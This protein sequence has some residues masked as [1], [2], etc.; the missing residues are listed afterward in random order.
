[1]LV[2]L[3]FWFWRRCQ[4][5]HRCCSS[6]FAARYTDDE[7]RVKRTVKHLA[8]MHVKFMEIAWEH[9]DL[10]NQNSKIYKTVCLIVAM[11]ERKA[12]E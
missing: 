1:M 8:P 7:I 3:F 2:R 12:C 6:L 5:R 4:C 9:S 11:H 10:M